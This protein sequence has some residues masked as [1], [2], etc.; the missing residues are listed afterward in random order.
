MKVH[1]LP[2]TA[3]T[4][5]NDLGVELGATDDINQIL[6]TLTDKISQILS[7]DVCSIYLYDP[8]SDSLTLVATHGLNRE[9]IHHVRI[10]AGEGLVGQT[11]RKLKPVSVARAARSKD[12]V[13][14]PGLG[15]ENFES[16]LSVPLVY[17]RSPV[18]VIVIQHRQPRKYKPQDIQMLLAL[19]IPTVSLIERSKFLG[20][21]GRAGAAP[22][23]DTAEKSGTGT[24]VEYLK[25]HLIKGIPASPGICMGKLRIVRPPL[26]RRQ[27]SDAG[28]GA[29][30]ETQRLIEAFAAVKKEIEQTK[31]L[32]EK[33]FGPDEASIFEAY[34]LFLES[35]PFQDQILVEVRKGLSAVRA[36]ELVVSKYIDRMSQGG[37]EYIKER[38]YDIQD[39]ARKISDYLLYGDAANGSKYT[40]D[41]DT[42]LLNDFWSISD[43]VGFDL[44]F[45]KGIISPQ[46]GASSH[47]AILADALNMPAV[48]GL[49]AT[50]TDLRD[51]DTV[52]MDGASGVVIVNPSPA[53]IDLYK[54]EERETQRRQST[55]EKSKSKHLRIEGDDDTYFNIGANLGMM[56][57][58]HK[59]LENGADEIGLYRTEFPFLIRKNLPTEEEQF[60]LYRRALDLMKGKSVTFRTLDIGGDKYVSYLNLPKESNPSLGWRSIRFSLERKDLFRIQLRALLRASAY[61]PM[62]LLFPMISAVDEIREVKTVLAAVKDELRDEKIR[63]A[64]KIPLGVMIEVP[65][66]VEIIGELAREVEY[67]SI[68][69]NDLVQY[70]LAVD[71]TNPLVADLYDPFHPAVLRTIARAIDAAKNHKRKIAVCGDIA[72]NPLLAAILIGLDIDSLSMNPGNIPRIKHFIKSVRKRELDRLA[73]GVLKMDSGTRIRAEIEKYFAT[74]G[75]VGFLPTKA[76]ERGSALHG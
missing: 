26:A 44:K 70:V 56:A 2:Q 39:V 5:I 69:S 18:G 74:S 23:A 13:F 73:Q 1:T 50:Y 67:F 45:I 29:E 71:R 75:L 55:F 10:K 16:F 12:F 11:I 49:G 46:G 40:A 19:A 33:K 76:Q 53:T 48:L 22:A 32:A 63:F 72:A 8:E 58:V 52:L 38:A 20:S 17:N 27:V 3:I 30:S 6:A 36:I 21:L 34:L 66:A 57:H 62:K 65:S 14:I 25:D 54:K 43:F 7:A 60:Q 64:R 4:E 61:G 31:R 37:D 35:Q 51:G 41:S 68:G 59:A 24:T 42:I 28:Q 47:I 9:F 15:E